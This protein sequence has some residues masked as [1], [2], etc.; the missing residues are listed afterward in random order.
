MVVTEKIPIFRTWLCE[1]TDNIALYS[2]NFN[3][4][5]WQARYE[6]SMFVRFSGTSVLLLSA[7]SA[8][9]ELPEKKSNCYY[10]GKG[11]MAGLWSVY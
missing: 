5:E 10:K 1:R 3:Y 9:S 11:V 2:L 6:A 7:K 4:F 8:I